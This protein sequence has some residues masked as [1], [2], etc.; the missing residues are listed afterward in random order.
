MVKY[1]TTKEL[2]EYLGI[3]GYVPDIQGDASQRS[4]ESLCKSSNNQ[5]VYLLQ[6]GCVLAGTEKIYYTLDGSSF[7]L[8]SAGQYGFDDNTGTVALT[9]A[10][11]SIVSA[12]TLYAEYNYNIVPIPDS[13]L[14][15]KIEEYSNSITSD[16]NIQFGTL[17]TATETL[18]SEFQKYDWYLQNTPIVSV[19]NLK[20]STDL[21]TSGTTLTTSTSYT[22]KDDIGLIKLD[23]FA[24]GINVTYTHGKST[25]P[26]DIKLLTKMLCSRDLM[27]KI[28]RF[29]TMK[30]M[31]DFNPKMVNVDDSLI[32]E[33]LNKYRDNWH[34]VI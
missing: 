17:Q 4:K 9:S 6:H 16:T 34:P 28:V 12:S 24:Y 2:S 20:V 3:L 31:N 30:A 7:T 18:S 26:T 25:I 14:D 11:E 13:E 22:K 33:I 1:I 29:A 27:H 19:S 8:L 5:S 23:N 10:T 32:E 15:S 21:I